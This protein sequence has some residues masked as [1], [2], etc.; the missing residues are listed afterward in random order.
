MLRVVAPLSLAV[1]AAGQGACDAD[2]ACVFEAKYNGKTYPMDFRRLCNAGQDYV[3]SDSIGHT[4]Y[5]QICGTA[6]KSCLPQDWE[7]EYEY[8]RVIQ[9]WGTPPTCDRSNMQCVEERTGA[10]VCCSEPCQVIAVQAPSFTEIVPGD[11][12]QG[13]QLTY[14]GET[15]TLSDPYQCDWNTQTGSPFPRV[16]HLQFF[17]DKTVTGYAQ[18]YAVDQNATDDCEY[19]VK[20]KT[21]LVC[22]TGMGLSGGWV[23]NIIVMTLF[24]VYVVA[25]Y[26]INYA[27]K[28]TCEF[29]NRAFWAEFESLVYDGIRFILAGCRKPAPRGAKKVAS[30]EQ[31]GASSFSADTSAQ[32]SAAM[33]TGSSGYDASSASPA[34]SS[35]SGYQGI[36]T[37][38][39]SGSNA[40]T[41]L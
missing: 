30:G 4:Y 21:S 34:S 33:F 39:G 38:S 9:T 28:K 20:F 18:M 29:P 27:R 3:L 24:G 10:E 6:A 32:A 11:A 13:V 37:S 8:G 14:Q 35:A 36:G 40:Y 31:Y 1:L 19:T 12:S 16:T 7:N 2:T 17:C 26:G 41:D 23:F 22:V 5:A 15:P 25:G